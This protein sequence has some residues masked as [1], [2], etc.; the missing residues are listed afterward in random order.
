MF[1]LVQEPHWTSLRVR[2]YIMLH[3]FLFFNNHIFYVIQF[4]VEALV[5]ILICVQLKL[6]YSVTPEP[7]LEN[8]YFFKMPLFY[9][10][11]QGLS[12]VNTLGIALA[13]QYFVF[14]GI[15]RAYVGT[16]I[17]LHYLVLL[18][19]TRA[20][21]RS[22]FYLGIGLALFDFI[23]LNITRASTGKIFLVLP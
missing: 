17:A 20:F 23:L 15:T 11:C 16:I 1:G 21:G 12:W 8:S 22:N 5:S 4:Y 14:S 6:N 13:L 18:D 9:M 7:W 2:L 3:Y 19:I 10:Y